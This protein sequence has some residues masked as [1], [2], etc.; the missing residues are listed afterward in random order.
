MSEPTY[1][2]GYAQNAAE[3]YE[4]YFVPA[5]N[6][7]GGEKGIGRGFQ[8]QMG[9]F[10]AGRLQTGGRA[11]GL[12]SFVGRTSLGWWANSLKPMR[13]HGRT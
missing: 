6:L 5:A 12:P 8:L 3:N 11:C 1:G 13:P 7:V 2:E 9:G 4:R 10:A